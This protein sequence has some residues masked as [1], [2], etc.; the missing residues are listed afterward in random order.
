MWLSRLSRCAGAFA[1][2]SGLTIAV[3]A[4][5]ADA[6]QPRNPVGLAPGAQRAAA[7]SPASGSFRKIAPGVEI[8]IPVHRPEQETFSAHDIV[9]LVNGVADLKWSPKLSP[10]TQTLYDMA[11]QHVF[12][13]DIWSLEL[14]FKPVR[15]IDVDVPLPNGKMQ[16][17]L[18]WYMVYHVKNTGGH[19][20]PT[21]QADGT[22]KATPL[23]YD[24]RFVP[25][26][27][28]ESPKYKKAYLDRTIPVAIAAIRLKEDPQRRLLNSVEMGKQSIPVT[29]GRVDKSVWG[30]VTWE[31]VD[32]RIDEFSIYVQGLSNAYKWVDPPGGFKPGSP[33]GTGRVLTFKTL[34]LNFWRPGDVYRERERSIHYGAPGKVDYTWIYR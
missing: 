27:V 5:Q 13:R 12:R 31:D 25:H 8:T 21:L 2:G 24:V 29:K 16:R 20:R 22:Y 18:I 7:A 28:L 9:E 3:A 32:P 30:V 19:L 33:P 4:A 23:D 34:V 26:F 14:T 1:L 6:L 17:K 11:S 10:N 15:M